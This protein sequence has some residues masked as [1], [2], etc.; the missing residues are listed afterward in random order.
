MFS[1]GQSGIAFSPLYRRFVQPW[2][3]VHYRPLWASG[4][5]AQT[6]VIRPK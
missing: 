5:P 3:D 6:L 2:A 4:P 1:S